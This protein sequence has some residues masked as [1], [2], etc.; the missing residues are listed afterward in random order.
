ML[1]GHE[2]FVPGGTGDPP[3]NTTH[4]HN[5]KCRLNN[6]SYLQAMQNLHQGLYPVLAVSHLVWRTID[7]PKGLRTREPC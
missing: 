7:G 4:R 6:D 3:P 2:A 1:Q 5:E